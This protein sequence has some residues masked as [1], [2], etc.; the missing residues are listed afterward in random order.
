MSEAPAPKPF[1]FLGDS[2]T[3]FA[4]WSRLF[5]E[6]SGVVNRGIQGNTARDVL[7]RMPALLPL[8]PRA[9]VMMIGTNDLL[10]G[11]AIPD[12]LADV[13]SILSSFQALRTRCTLLAV[14]PVREAYDP[15]FPG[16]NARAA[17][18]NREL[19]V[20]AAELRVKYV[21]FRT[22]FVDETGELRAELTDDGVHILPEGYAL[23]AEAL[24]K[25]V[26]FS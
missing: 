20:L 9:L 17:Q 8:E 24:Q 2:L 7:R 14:L 22:P 23:W 25:S 16:F 6:V 19:A 3:A 4:P 13:R 10:Q 18:Y 1:L 12:I 5:P 11:R 26:D 15:I 21:N